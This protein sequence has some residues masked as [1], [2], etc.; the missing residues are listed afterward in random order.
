M[1]KPFDIQYSLFDIRYSI[2]VIH[3]MRCSNKLLPFSVV[4]YW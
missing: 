2:P 1:E 4:F 3:Q